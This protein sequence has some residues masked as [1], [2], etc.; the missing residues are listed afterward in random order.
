VIGVDTDTD[1]DTMIMTKKKQSNS[2]TD[3]WSE[4]ERRISSSLRHGA[5]A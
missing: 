4:K 2:G 3:A 1:T 5:A